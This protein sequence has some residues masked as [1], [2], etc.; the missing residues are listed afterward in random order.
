MSEKKI[1]R[2]QLELLSWGSESARAVFLRVSAENPDA[3]GEALANA[4]AVFYDKRAYEVAADAKAEAD[5]RCRTYEAQYVRLCKETEEL[6]AAATQRAELAESALE[7]ERGNHIAFREANER[8]VQR[9]ITAE[10][11]LARA[12]VL[13]ESDRQLVLM[14]L[15]ILSLECPGFDDALNRIAVRIDNIAEGRSVMYDAFR[16]YRGPPILRPTPR[17]AEL[18]EEER[19][20]QRTMVSVARLVGERDALRSMLFECSE[21]LHGAYSREERE[22]LAGQIDR[23]LRPPGTIEHAAGC[24]GECRMIAHGDD[25]NAPPDACRAWPAPATIGGRPYNT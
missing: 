11:A 18:N 6:I 21:A 20:H 9:A 1:T 12:L 23:V 2:E 7:N 14:A 3:D 24:T 13:E 10:T 19:A 4:M 15:A 25:P 16:K 5:D 8:A 17:D 22:I